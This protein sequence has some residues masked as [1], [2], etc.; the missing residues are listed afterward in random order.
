MLSRGIA[1]LAMIW[2]VLFAQS[3]QAFFDPPWITP[4]NPK[5]GDTIFVNINYGI[6]NGIFW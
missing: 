6:C 5:A 2:L 3:A 1:L 4:K